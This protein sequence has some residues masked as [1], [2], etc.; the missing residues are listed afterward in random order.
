MADKKIDLNL[1][2]IE[3]EDLVEI[4][5]QVLKQVAIRA[6]LNLGNLAAVH[7]SHSSNHSNHSRLADIQEQLSQIAT[8]GQK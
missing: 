7:D 5:N 8:R 6:K 4:Q 2:D 3:L 1:K